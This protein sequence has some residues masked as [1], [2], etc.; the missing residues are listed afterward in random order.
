MPASGA[1]C[2]TVERP[3]IRHRISSFLDRQRSW[4]D[5]EARVHFGIGCVLFR[6]RHWQPPGQAEILISQGERD[7][8]QAEGRK[9]P[10]VFAQE[11]REDRQAA[12]VGTF[13]TREA[14]QKHEREV[15]L[16]Q[17]SEGVLAAVAS[18]LA[19]D[20]SLPNLGAPV[21]TRYY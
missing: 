9:V 3:Q 17:W 15:A 13:D 4:T 21:R 2:K 12:Q 14:A 8:P 18:D 1:C 19:G 6:E 16:F 10:A 5:A 7:D 11:G 20:L